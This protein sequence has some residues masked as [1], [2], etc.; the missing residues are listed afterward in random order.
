[1]AERLKHKMYAIP[2]EEARQQ[3]AKTEER[4]A[5]HRAAAL[6]ATRM[7]D[8]HKDAGDTDA[9]MALVRANAAIEL[10][11]AEQR[12][13]ARAQET[14]NEETKILVDIEKLVD[15]QLDDSATE[16]QKDKEYNDNVAAVQAAAENKH[17]SDRKQRALAISGQTAEEQQAA[18]KKCVEEIV[19]RQK[20][21]GSTVDL[22]LATG[23]CTTIQD[24]QDRKYLEP[25]PE[26]K[27]QC[28]LLAHIFNLVDYK[29]TKDKG[30]KSPGLPA[31]PTAK[32]RAYWTGLAPK[33]AS[34]IVDGDPYKFMNLL[35]QYPS[36]KHLHNL[37][38]AEI[39]QLQPMIRLYKVTETKNYPFE[40][41]HEMRF[42]SHLNKRDV[43][44]ELLLSKTCR[45]VGVGIQDFTFSYEADNP[46][47]IKKSIKAKL[48]LFANSF[49]ELL[50]DRKDPLKGDEDSWTYADLA[51]KTGSPLVKN[52]I[53][54][55]NMGGDLVYGVDK[56]NFRLKAVV[57]WASAAAGANTVFKS[58]EYSTDTE[59][60]QAIYNSYVSLNLTPTV[61][62][63]D[64]DEMGRVTF[65]INYLAYIE[66]FFD[67]PGF[68]I[69]TDE[70]STKHVLERKL[71]YQTLVQNCTNA[72]TLRKKKEEWQKDIEEDRKRS[73]KSLLT[74]MNGVPDVEKTDW[75]EHAD[76]TKIY[77]IELDY[78]KVAEFQEKGPYSTKDSDI[79]GS[80]STDVDDSVLTAILDSVSPAAASS[81]ASPSAS[82]PKTKPNVLDDGHLTFFY[83]S[84]LIDVILASIGSSLKNQANWINGGLA[85][86]ADADIKIEETKKLSRAAEA[87][88]RLRVV[89][90]PLEITH[91]L[92]PG[93]SKFISLGDVPI[94]LKYFMQWLTKKT[95]QRKEVVYT[96]ANF[97]N[98]FLNEFVRE[99]LGT[100]DCFNGQLRQSVRL[101]QA[102][103]TAY[104]DGP[105]HYDQITAAMTGNVPW[106]VTTQQIE[107]IPEE[108]R[109][110]LDVAGPK[111][112]PNPVPG[113]KGEVL[114]HEMNYLVYYA[115]RIMPAERAD[116]DKK[117]DEE[118]GIYHYGIGKDRGL[119]K[120][121]NF[122]KT[123]S[124]GLK[125]LRF[126]QQGYDGLQQLRE[127]YDVEIETY[128]NVGTFP[129]VYIYVEPESVAP[130]V[131]LDALK[132]ESLTQLG[133][134]GYHMIIRSEHRFGAGV[135]NSTITAKWVAEKYDPNNPP[136]MGSIIQRKCQRGS[137]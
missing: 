136:K 106:R 100:G 110:L 62:E 88:T 3:V 35:T 131:D 112:K 64:I 15:E 54:S 5:F 19:A 84:D 108:R 9:A 10:A 59:K 77:I 98:A 74:Q 49:G 118:Q 67:Q 48:T 82:G 50:R 24:E 26:Y 20:K 90:G 33:N 91:P 66:D 75:D 13:A 27:E 96:L 43:T 23:L 86:Q 70:E 93:K 130:N 78:K 135:A 41:M 97:L 81:T 122:R 83:V 80:I 18:H 31:D 73:L 39:S 113:D 103:V 63:F 17:S 61:H 137:S 1:M 111:N 128:S 123:D 109:P 44:E 30:L 125:E 126:E 4:L 101:S 36:H 29:R 134:G 14:L 115:G 124:P 7:A 57:G 32:A 21:T 52:Y 116:G 2:V 38:A 58:D 46:F 53:E 40:K 12:Q 89:L 56:L 65:T 127:M 34:L 76:S 129:G 107:G 16:A 69:F 102:A 94:S 120:T 119:V 22:S 8:Q 55:R 28:Y 105:Y 104:R 37:S 42:D 60:R 45:G 79:S 117:K 121:I 72:D 68:N 95:L 51:L 71:V 47:A 133:I 11:A 85:P 87:F 132:I 99:F 92:D 25:K 6:E 114:T